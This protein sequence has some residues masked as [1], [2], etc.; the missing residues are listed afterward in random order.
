MP[1]YEVLIHVVGEGTMRGWEGDASDPPKAISIA[2]MFFKS[3]LLHETGDWP[4]FLAIKCRK[5]D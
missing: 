4:E 3:Q 5:V 1:C 2:F